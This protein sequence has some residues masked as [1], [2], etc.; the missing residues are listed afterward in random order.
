MAGP[1]II[2]SLLAGAGIGAAATTASENS[3]LRDEINA[4]REENAYIRGRLDERAGRRR[5]RRIGR[6]GEASLPGD[7]EAEYR[8]VPEL[9]EC[10]QVI[11][12]GWAERHDGPGTALVR[13]GP[14]KPLLLEGDNGRR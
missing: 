7:I 9:S 4:L 14:R 1:L 3:R 6:P 12:M 2:L 11:N 10:R 8:A 13:R 5:R